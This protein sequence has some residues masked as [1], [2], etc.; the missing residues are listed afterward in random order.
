[1]NIEIYGVFYFRGRCVVLKREEIFLFSTFLILKMRN[2]FLLFIRNCRSMKNTI[3]T[4]IDF[5]NC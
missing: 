3:G 2:V 4:V 5:L 1:M